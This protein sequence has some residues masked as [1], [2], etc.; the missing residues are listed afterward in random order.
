MKKERTGRR[1]D[2]N[3][4]R[5]RADATVSQHSF[6]SLLG[7]SF[8]L[9]ALPLS[10]E[11]GARRTNE[12]SEP[13]SSTLNSFSPPAHFVRLQAISSH[14]LC[15]PAINQPRTRRLFRPL[16][17]RPSARPTSLSLSS[18]MPSHSS[19]L[20][21]LSPT[22]PPQV[23]IRDV[24]THNLRPSNHPPPINRTRISITEKGG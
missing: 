23:L 24:H 9:S 8:S 10:Q 22:S 2:S 11:R 7:F 3:H 1:D 12:T 16:D 21:S 14:L 17:S 18:L 20:S 6:V 19:Q 13:S 4:S 5:S 15:S